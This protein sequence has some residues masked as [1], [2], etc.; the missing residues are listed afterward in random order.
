MKKLYLPLILIAGIIASYHFSSKV[1]SDEL[2][3][4]NIADLEFRKKKERRQNGY[5]KTDKPDEYVKYYNGIRTKDGMSSSEYPSNYKIAE[6]NKAKTLLTKFSKSRSRAESATLDW[7]QRGPANVP[8]RTR[9]LVVFTDDPALDTWLAA[10]VGGGLWKTTDGGDLWVSKTDDFPNLA[11]SYFGISE[12]NQNIIYA[13]TGE[14]FFN[15]GAIQGDGILKSIDQGETWTLLPSTIANNKFGTI[16]RLAVD[17]T[18]P[19]ILV[20]ATQS[21]VGNYIM[22]SIDGGSSWTEVYSSS[23]RIQDLKADP[24]DFNILY[25]SIN[26]T[27][28]VKSIDAGDTWTNSSVG[29][30]PSGRIEVA[31]SPVNTNRVFLS[32]EGSLSGNSSDLYISD[33]GGANWSVVLED[34]NGDETNFLGGQGWYDNTIAADPYDQDV[35]YYG[36]VNIWKNT[37][38]PG[39]EPGEVLSVTVD[40]DNTDSFLSFTNFSAQYFGGS[41]D[42][43]TV[44]ASEFVSVE[45]RFGQGTQMAHRFAIPAGQ[46]SGVAVSDYTYEDYVEVPF[47]AW[48]IVNNQQLMVSFRDQQDDGLFNLIESNT[49]GDPTTHSR[50]YLFVHKENYSA[51]ASTDISVAGGQEVNQMYFTWPVLASGGTWDKDALPVSTLR[52]NYDVIIVDFRFGI[53]QNLTDA[54]NEFSGNNTYSSTGFHPDQHELLMLKVDEVSETFKIL[55]SNDGGIFISNTSTQPGVNNGDWTSKNFGYI[56]GQFYGAD[57]KRGANEYL[58]GLQDNGTWMSPSGENASSTTNYEFKIGGDGFEVLWNYKDTQKAIGGSQYNGFRRTTNGGTTWVGATS[59]LSGDHPFISKLEN[60]NANPDVIF[61]VS[62]SGVF[63]STDFGGSWN[64]TSI[65]DNWG[66]GSFLDVEVSLAN[67]NVVWAGSSLS[68]SS[69]LHFS[70]DNG[71]NFSEANLFADLS[72]RISGLETH[73]TEEATAYALFSFANSPKILR[74]TDMGTSWEDIS[75]F[76]TN[77]TS[78]NGF[79]DVAVYSLLVMP[80]DT[81]VIWAGTEIGIFESLDNGATWQYT[82]NGFP[83][84]SVWQMKVVDDQIVVATHGRGIWSVTIP[85]LAYSQSTIDET[86]YIGNQTMEVDIDLL[87]GFDSLKIF[88]DDQLMTTITTGLTAGVHTYE[89]AKTT[90]EASEIY[91]VSYL[92]ATGYTSSIISSVEADFTPTINNL[93]SNDPNELLFDIES[94]ENYSSIE[95]YLD[96]VKVGE[97]TSPVA[98]QNEIIVTGI[99]HKIFSGHIVGILD[100][101]PYQSSSVSVQVIASL[102]SFWDDKSV[103]IYPNPASNRLNIEVESGKELTEIFIYNINGKL[104]RNIGSDKTS[105]YIGEFE[106]GVYFVNYKLDG[107]DFT[108]RII[109]RH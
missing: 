105:I 96:D 54:Y 73:P 25:A 91:S 50:E 77:D 26:S 64:L 63:R 40:E 30:Q 10:S 75:G 81:N 61:T 70:T 45:I 84:A 7:T 38:V 1:V 95:L 33:D 79:P 101:Q 65:T 14:G 58:G 98:G 13:G 15:T 21:T 88:V 6:L 74:T 17:D 71:L 20:V 59:G 76:G 27:G 51:T 72:G 43:G 18:N 48:D 104:M 100:G 94:T 109:V 53:T 36:G 4:S 57:K 78:S 90:E 83:A 19:N 31:I 106:D 3:S 92:G 44:A 55:N 42:L 39:S 37:I 12:S 87:T 62:T 93:V 9:G 85:E 2:T 107:K 24:S 82:N 47:Q 41:L 46:G 66:S 108:E 16:N 68:A 69:K 102:F 49:S 28:V 8:G 11:I 67:A 99:D 89:V 23:S 103:S 52:I 60:S 29:L 80:H 97:I 56:T 22:K 32:V 35:V 86:R 5:Y 34:D